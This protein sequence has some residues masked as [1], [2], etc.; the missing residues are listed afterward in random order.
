MNLSIRLWWLAGLAAVSAGCSSER[1]DEEPPPSAPPTIS[2]APPTPAPSRIGVDGTQPA[3][4]SPSVP[5]GPRL[6][7]AI[8]GMSETDA[9]PL[10]NSAECI[11][12]VASIEEC[13]RLA[14]QDEA[15]G[16]VYG[17]KN[18]LAEDVVSAWPQKPSE[19]SVLRHIKFPDRVAITGDCVAK[20]KRKESVRCLYAALLVDFGRWSRREK[21]LFGD[22]V[23]AVLAKY[24][25][26]R[27]ESGFQQTRWGMTES[28]VSVLFPGISRKPSGEMATRT[29]VANFPAQVHFLFVDGRLWSVDVSFDVDA[30][31]PDQDVRKTLDLR[32]LLREKYGAPKSV[33]DGS[34]SGREVPIEQLLREF[35]GTGRSI[36]AGRQIMEATWSTKDMVI[37]LML[38]SAVGE[39]SHHL[40]Y[41]ST[42]FSERANAAREAVRSSEL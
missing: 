6:P 12:A 2:Q 11:A 30:S 18:T 33:K 13:V 38:G 25:A 9:I 22:A 7:V 3:P 23:A 20:L 26:Y 19:F 37:D 4:A 28:E 35:G 17:D 34:P 42:V 1:R 41:R 15:E 40:V 31:I 36:R 24:Q 29:A 16:F 21:S 32:R 5:S 14:T 27:S 10:A 8:E 39:Y